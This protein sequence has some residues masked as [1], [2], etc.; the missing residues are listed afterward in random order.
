MLSLISNVFQGQSCCRCDSWSSPECTGCE[1]Y[2]SSSS[3][4]IMPSDVIAVEFD[5]ISIG[6]Y[7]IE[8][9]SIVPH[10][11]M[12]QKRSQE[13]LTLIDCIKAFHE[14]EILD[15]DNPWYCPSCC[16]NQR[17]N[18][19]LSIWKSPKTLMVYLKRFLF[20]EMQP[21][22][23]DD[24]VTFPIDRLDMGQF[25]RKRTKVTALNNVA[26]C[27]KDQEEDTGGLYTLQSFVCHSGGKFF[28]L[29]L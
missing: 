12:N 26:S 6:D 24:T 22:K 19:T 7:S 11:S 13:P 14:S 18:K 20:H 10:E 8:V 29:I 4:F 23:V 9:P 16:S 1:I 21:N 25:I 28:L 3:M 27:L 5:P 2:R 17:A 15:S